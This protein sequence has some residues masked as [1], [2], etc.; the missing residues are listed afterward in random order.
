MIYI[1]RGLIT[2]I[3]NQTGEEIW[4]DVFSTFISANIIFIMNNRQG[5]D[6]E[7]NDQLVYI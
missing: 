2:M 5:P 7:L 1:K 6:I 3:N 4:Y